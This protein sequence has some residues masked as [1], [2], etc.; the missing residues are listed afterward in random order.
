[1]HAEPGSGSI[2]QNVWPLFLSVQWLAEKLGPNGRSGS[3]NYASAADLATMARDRLPNAE[4]V[5]FAGCSH[6]PFFED[7]ELYIQTVNQ[8]IQKTGDHP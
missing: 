6:M 4:L 1:M 8:F 5:L 2:F 7:P 3:G